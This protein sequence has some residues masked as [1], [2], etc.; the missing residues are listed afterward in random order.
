MGAL[1]KASHTARMTGTHSRQLARSLRRSQT[2][3]EV[4]LWGYLRARRLDGLKFRRQAP[5]A[6]YIADFACHDAKLIVELDGSQHAD[7]QV[8]DTARS[9]ALRLVGYEVIR[10]WNVDVLKDIEAVL[11]TILEHVHGATRRHEDSGT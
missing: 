9:D 7:R 10:F 1:S 5:I 6:G 8:A 11:T 3:A 4:K 2:D